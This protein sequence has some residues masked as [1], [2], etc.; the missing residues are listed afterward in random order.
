MR[1]RY[2]YLIKFQFLGFRYHGWQKQPDV[3]TVEEKITKTIR[4]ILK[5][6]IR[7]KILGASR[8]DAKVSGMNAAF[9]LFLEEK[10][11]DSINTF[12][13]ELN[14]NLPPD[15]KANSILEVNNKFNIIQSVETKEYVYLFSFGSKNHPYAAPYLANILEPL[16]IDLMIK[17]AKLFEG[18]HYFRSYCGRPTDD[19]NFDRELLSC[20]LLPNSFLK[21]DFFPDKSY[22]LHVRGKGFLRY[23]IRLI[24]GALIKLGKGEVD[25]D[26]IKASLKK[27]NA[28]KIDLVAPAS[29]LHL[30][31]IKFDE[32]SF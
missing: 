21:A 31:A 20:E 32:S 23:Q 22:A 2:Y 8:T 1:K 10:P 13:M 30:K 11:L 16:D 15:I 28:L 12:L 3:K 24:M 7:F 19:M 29:G 6:T 17:G 27:N 9:E 14:S 5:D 26:F 18:Q 25:L 4:F